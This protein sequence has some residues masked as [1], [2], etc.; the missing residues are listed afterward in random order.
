[1]S[2]IIFLVIFLVNFCVSKD[3][4]SYI[5]VCSEKDPKLG[6][7]IRKAINSLRPYL[8]NGIP[9]LEI[10]PID[11]LFVPKIEITQTGGVQ[12]TA[13]FTNISIYGAGD[14]RLRS[15]R[16]DAESNK[17]RI[18]LW[19][20]QLSMKAN[21]N[22]QGQLLMLPVSGQGKC[23]GNF[24]DIDGAV[25]MQLDRVKKN[26][27]EHFKTN[28]LNIQFNIG[29][30]TA[31]LDNLFNGDKELG[32]SINS[33]INENW[34][35]VTAEIRPTLEST[36]AKILMEISEKFFDQFPIKILFSS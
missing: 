27:N 33:F 31:R 5:N 20:P 28:F 3:F 18:K 30:A 19:Y 1:M 15:V 9:E 24:T 13:T 26:G 4:P 23:W 7:C 32:D 22:I 34:R 10:P 16:V 36:I 2:R 17:M 11:P 14:F 25:S 6:V 29:G 12:L 21:Y 8:L 35:I